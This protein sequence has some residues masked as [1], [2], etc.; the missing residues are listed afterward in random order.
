[1]HPGR[2]QFSNT[3]EVQSFRVANTPQTAHCRSSGRPDSLWVNLAVTG[4]ALVGVLAFA[5]V[6]RRLRIAHQAPMWIAK[7]VLGFTIAATVWSAVAVPLLPVAL[8]TG[9]PFE[10]AILVLTAIATLAV[11]VAAQAGR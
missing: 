5:V 3:L 8:V 6:G 1:M 4:I 7:L 2:L 10:H 9:A 11:A